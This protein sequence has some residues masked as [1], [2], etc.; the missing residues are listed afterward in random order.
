LCGISQSV[1]AETSCHAAFRIV[2]VPYYRLMSGDV[3]ELRLPSAE[4]EARFWALVEAAWA[5]CGAEAN[6]VRRA[7]AARSGPGGGLSAVD[8]ALPVFLGALADQ[9]RALPGG[10]L[11]SL[12]RVVERKLYDIDRVD[13][14]A[15]TDGSDD[16]FLYARGFIVAMGRDFY[17]AVAGDPQVAVLEA[18]C[19]QMCYFFAHRYC[20]RFGQFPETGSGISRESCSNTTGWAS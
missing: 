17:D 7:L 5:Q 11:I 6:R 2:D 12:D 9:C 14:Q 1:S 10:E 20:E 8:N 15:V 13:I 4:D 19:E 3:D 16:G 18:E